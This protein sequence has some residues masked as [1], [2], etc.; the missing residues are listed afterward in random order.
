MDQPV[1][2]AVGDVDSP[3][4][5]PGLLRGTN[6]GRLQGQATSAQDDLFWGNR[7]RPRGGSPFRLTCGAGL[8]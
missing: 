4:P 2:S 7:V 6:Y 3:N 1:S 5:F 8:K